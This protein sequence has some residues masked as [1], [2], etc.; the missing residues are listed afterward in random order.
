MSGN[1]FISLGVFRMQLCRAALL[2]AT[3]IL[4]PAM[5]G[6]S[7]ATASPLP[8][9]P[10]ALMT[11]AHDK[12]GLTGPDIKP[13]HMRGTYHSYKEGTLDYEGAYEEWWF[14]PTQ[15]K[16]SFTTPNFTQTDYATGT[17]LLRDGAQEWLSGPELLLGA[18]LVDPLPDAGLLSNFKLRRESRSIGQAK[19][20]CVTH[21]YKT[22]TGPPAHNFPF[23]CFELTMPVL[24]IFG[25][26]FGPKIQ[27]DHIV[28]IQGHYIAHQ[29]QVFVG[30]NLVADLNI[31]LIQGINQLPETVLTPPA[32]ALPVN[33][34]RIVFKQAGKHFWP[35]PLIIASPDLVLDSRMSP[36]EAAAPPAPGTIAFNQDL[37]PEAR[38]ELNAPKLAH[39]TVVVKLTIR[40]DGHV[41]RA[42]VVS[43]IVGLQQGALD[44]ARQWVFR[45]VE[46]LGAARP[47]EAEL[48]LGG[49]FLVH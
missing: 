35:M 1:Q 32:S 39:G 3:L 4:A 44:A 30:D 36:G 15:Y 45:P 42:D 25:Q 2:L 6:L 40:P 47:V 19:L 28:L 22:R 7:Q 12:N 27:Y 8:Q 34:S 5:N 16:L 14:S 29:I 20:E 13:W 41:E 9:D 49:D 24:R 48:V 33:L 46:V 11:L 17:A 38:A 10:T 31:D 26:G 21:T 23:A 37:P 18:S 43:G